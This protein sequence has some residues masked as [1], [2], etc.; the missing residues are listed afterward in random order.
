MNDFIKS[1]IIRL[2]S[3]KAGYDVSTTAGAAK[4]DLSSGISRQTILRLAGKYE[5]T[6]TQRRSTLDVLAQ[7][8]GY[9]DFP[10]L[11][12]AIIDGTSTFAPIPGLVVVDDLPVNTVIDVAWAPDRELTLRLLESGYL[13]V[14]KAA[15]SKI[16]P[17]DLLKIHQISPE[18]EMSVMDVIRD[19]Q[20]MGNYTAAEGPG[21]TKVKVTR[22]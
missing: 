15:N 5:Y 20:S 8:L 9:P 7:Y 4:L 18:H 21:L 13:R 19:G 6:G 11:E 16:I 10:T 12:R 2:L 3:Q 17:G 14:E 1:E 22:E